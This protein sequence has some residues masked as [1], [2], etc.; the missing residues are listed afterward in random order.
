MTYSNF[1]ILFFL[2]ILMEVQA[3]TNKAALI[4]ITAFCGGTEIE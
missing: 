4:K 3:E 2:Y 1:L